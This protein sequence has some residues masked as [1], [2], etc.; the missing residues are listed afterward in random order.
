MTVLFSCMLQTKLDNHEYA[1][2]AEFADDVRQIFTNCY[3]YNP[4][5]TDIVAMG[6]KTQ[7]T[8]LC[9]YIL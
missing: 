8:I 6:K 3:R 4:P 1:T 5:E 7:V 9:C 2:A